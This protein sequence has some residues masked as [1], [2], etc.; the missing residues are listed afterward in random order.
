MEVDVTVKKLADLFK[1]TIIELQDEPEFQW[2]REGIKYAVDEKGEPCLKLTMGNVPLDYDL[3]EGLRNPA[4][5]GLY[6][7]GLQEI[8]EFFANRRKTGIDESG[9]QTIFQIARSYDFA[10][11][12]Y[13]R[14]L[15]IS[16]MLPFSLK[17]I[18][19]YTQFFLKEKEGS[20]HTFSRMYE[21][22]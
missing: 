10:R 22:G 8:W 19:S 1:G 17:T 14:A 3:W 16:V 12:N 2:K 11:K 18:D 4:L 7:V 21:D 5:V 13:T 9:R 20:S 15:I 6:P